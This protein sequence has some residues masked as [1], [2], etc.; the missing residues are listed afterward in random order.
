MIMN[1]FLSNLKTATNFDTTTNGAT[2]HRTT[3]SAV[4]NLF[5]LGGAYRNRSDQDCVTL[6][7]DAWQENPDLALKCLFYLRDILEGQGQRR[8]FRVCFQWLAVYAPEAARKN[9]TNIPTFGRWDDLIY[10]TLDTPVEKD[11]LEIIKHQ[12]ALDA[13]CKTPS[14]LS[15]WMPSENASSEKTK[16]TAN[17]IRTYLGF[18][19]KEYRKLLSALRKKINVLERL[20]SANEWDKIEFDKIPSKAG[21]V[22]RNA[23]ARR[24]IIAEKYKKFATSRDIK[25]NVKA[26]YPYEVVSQVTD[27][28]DYGWWGSSEREISETE[29]AII[30]KY[31]ENL[32]D[33][34]EGKTS[35]ILCVCDT[36]GS[37]HGTPIDVA[38]SLSLY[39]AER[40]DGPFKNHYISFSS[41]P[42]LIETKGFDFVDKV[43]RIYKTNLCENTDL[44]KVFDLLKS[45]A[46]N[47]DTDKNTLPDT[48]VV[49]S[50]MQIDCGSYGW[51]A[52][53]TATEMEQIRKDWENAGLVLPR[54]VYWDVN[55]T[56]DTFLDS[57]SN[58]S[59]VSG[60]SQILFQQVIQG[61]TGMDIMTDKLNSDRY[62]CVTI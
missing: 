37:M 3:G 16:A 11:A 48:I 30:N 54:L 50:D 31:W 17:V 61:K 51:T 39:C 27:K 42:Q 5:A 13:N 44:V 60:F 38:I 1:T 12:L 24:D 52:K 4:Y 21:L 62:S 28:M 46:L 7:S 55:A 49:I 10:S 19:H 14:L 58:V 57:G 15:K 53:N 36:S 18:S 45:V 29:R 43:K 9:L 2:A 8:F 32:P 20:M 33:Y 47:P 23:F 35:N 56:K 6:F 59:F 25:V 41:T 34:F 22:Y 26:L 40:L